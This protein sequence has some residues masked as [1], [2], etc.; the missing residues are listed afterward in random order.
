MSTKNVFIASLAI[1]TLFLAIGCDRMDNQTIDEIN[2]VGDAIGK[3][4]DTVIGA[5]PDALGT[6]AFVI[7][8]T[9]IE[10]DTLRVNVSYTGGCETHAFTLVA[11]PRF[12]ES[13]PVQVHVSL[14]H[15]ANGD[16]CQDS[17]TEDYQFDLTPIKTVYQKGYRTDTGTIVLRLKG[18]P[19]G[20]LAYEFYSKNRK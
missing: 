19:S 13:F 14:A 1:C 4:G 3:I 18:A 17:I 11:E 20:E 16:T 9:T 6:D 2:E 8:A 5:T 7:N 15:N 12:L 10:A